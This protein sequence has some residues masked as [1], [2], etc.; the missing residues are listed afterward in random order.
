MDAKSKNISMK[1]IDSN[2]GSHPAETHNTGCQT[3]GVP[4][5]RN[6]S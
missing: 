1:G 3:L 6:F 5:Y 2:S 4:L